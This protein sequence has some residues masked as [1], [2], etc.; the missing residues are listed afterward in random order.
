MKGWTY[1][2]ARL[3]AGV[4]VVCALGFPA[5]ALA[6]TGGDSN[7]GDVW[8]DTVGEPAGPGHEMDPH[9]P[10]ADINLW[11][12]KLADSG[13]SY[14]I[15]GW[16]PSGSKA[17]AYSSTWKY[18]GTQ[19]GSQVIDVINVQ[20]LVANAAANGDAPVNGNGYH[21][22]LEFS[23]DPQ[24]HKTFWVNCPPPSSTSTGTPGGGTDQTQS[25]TPT[26][27]GNQQAVLGERVSGHSRRARRKHRVRRHHR[28]H[29]QVRR[30]A[31]LP[32]FTG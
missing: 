12:D 6:A 3:V 19:G 13:G 25:S 1:A 10:C 32:A 15:D 31:V 20:T 8:V 5:S 21:F 22:K 18:D 26:P 27:S 14:T 7:A 17:Q 2:P 9:L 28:K 29:H 24:K 23:Q 11:G 4:L 16:P 30:Q